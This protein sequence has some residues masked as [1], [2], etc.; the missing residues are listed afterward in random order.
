MHMYAYRPSLCL[1]SR[2][3]V[4][5]RPTLLPLWGGNTSSRHKSTH[6]SQFGHG[7]LALWYRTISKVPEGHHPRGTTLH[8]ALRGNALGGSL[9]GLCGGLSE[10][11]RGS[12]GFSEA[13][14]GSDPM[15]VTLANCWNYGGAIWKRHAGT[16][17][18]LSL[19]YMFLCVCAVRPGCGPPLPF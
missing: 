17:W 2:P 14:R 15:L 16:E 1:H 10:V 18:V 12:A 13:F 6:H 9:R 19:S 4:S 3:C 7:L 8:E 5:D 11:L